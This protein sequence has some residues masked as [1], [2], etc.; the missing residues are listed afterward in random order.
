M[1]VKELIE[2]LQAFDP[3][4]TV[5]YSDSEEGTTVVYDLGTIEDAYISGWNKATVL[6]LDG[7]Y[8]E[9]KHIADKYLTKEEPRPYNP[10]PMMDVL[11]AEMKA[12][13][14]ASLNSLI[15][16]DSIFLAN[17]N[18]PVNKDGFVEFKIIK[19]EK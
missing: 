11:S 10:S 13:Y 4:L 12:V 14:A 1:K 7:E 8:A 17:P 3:E 18:P 15:A 6:S 16:R 5:T 2:K 19:G 9:P